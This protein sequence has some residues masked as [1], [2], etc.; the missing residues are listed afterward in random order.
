[1]SVDRP[2]KVL[3]YLLAASQFTH[4]MDFMIIMP[5]SE[6]FMEELKISA[7]EFAFLVA[8]YT[9]TAGISGL[10]SAFFVDRFDRKKYF[11]MAYVGFTIGT[12][13]CGLSNTYEA[14]VSARIFTGIFGGVISSTVLAIVS[15]IIPSK[16]RAWGI[17][18]VMSA[19]SIASAFG[20][21]V[22]LYF[23][24]NFGWQLPFLALGAVSMLN[25]TAVYFMLPPVRGHLDKQSKGAQTTVSFILNIPRNR[26]QWMALTFTMLLIYGQ[27]MV[28]PFITPYLVHNVGFERE[29]I[30]FVYLIG[31]FLT[32]ITNP[33]V[34]RWADNVGRHKVFM[35]LAFLSIIP[36]LTLTN[37]PPV[38]VWMALVVTAALFV[39]IGG[40]MVPSTT[41]V[42]SVIKPENRGSFMSLN[43]ST[44]S[45]TA[46]LSSIIAGVLVSISPET[47]KVLG[48][49][50]VGVLA[51]AFTLVA[52]WMMS[53]IQS[54]KEN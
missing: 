2:Q 4:I 14:L 6:M 52:I 54:L 28:V 13:L 26:N 34:G 40:R 36:L 7:R 20:L 11:L 29:Q 12:F 16:H 37:L 21:P 51:V 19:F 32:M 9:I 35:I 43:S 17:G 45:M 49:W 1:M 18:I 5:L 25:A 23:A 42:T 41:I 10:I 53:Q 15:D 47:G 31:G 8:S 50:S 24:F 38:P 3:L 39:T 22:G 33:R 48:F 46:G 27:F 44:Q 30:T